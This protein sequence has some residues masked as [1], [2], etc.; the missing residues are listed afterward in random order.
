M[1][2]GVISGGWTFVCAAYIITAL[3]LGGYAWSVLMRYRKE[4]S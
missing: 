2:G 4:R 1:T 3:V